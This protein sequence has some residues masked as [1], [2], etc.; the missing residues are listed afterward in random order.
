MSPP[1]TTTEKTV[2]SKSVLSVWHVHDPVA[3]GSVLKCPS[4]WNPLQQMVLGNSPQE[5][6]ER[7][8]KQQQAEEQ[9]RKQQLARAT[10]RVGLWGAIGNLAATAVE[11][12]GDKAGTYKND[13]R[14]H[15][16]IGG[17]QTS[18]DTCR[19]KLTNTNSTKNGSFRVELLPQKENNQQQWE[20]IFR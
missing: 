11:A 5:Q 10:Q 17:Y 6:K 4:H 14:D 7:L 1:S 18:I 19:G 9:R 20:V 8:A 12:V 15:H 13:I 3:N 16:L 2:C